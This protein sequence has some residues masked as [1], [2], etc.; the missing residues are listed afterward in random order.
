MK[1]PDF[2]QASLIFDIGGVLFQS[3][4]GH[5]RYIQEPHKEPAPGEFIPIQ[6][7]IDLL[8]E[9]AAL[10]DEYGNRLHK[11]FILSNWN[12]QSFKQLQIEHKDLF[13]LF[14]GAIISGTL[15]FSKP[16]VRIYH[17]LLTTYQLNAGTC[18]FIDDIS[19]NIEAAETIGITSIHHACSNKTRQILKTLGVL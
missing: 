12:Q 17:H 9:C 13:E 19:M 6:E 10:K 4:Y 7:G 5:P 3:G 8:L 16:D 18:I 11:L 1:K 15:P 14:E 2:W